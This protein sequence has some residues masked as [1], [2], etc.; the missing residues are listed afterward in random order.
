MDL[1]YAAADFALCRAGAMTCAELTAV[2]L[3]GAYVPLPHG[4]GEQRLNAEPIVAG[5]GGLMVDDAD[6]TP[7]WIRTVLL[8][9]LLDI[10]RVANMSEAA[11]ALGRKDADR[12]LAAAVINVVRAAHEAAAAPGATARAARPGS[13]SPPP[14]SPPRGFA[15]RPARRAPRALSPRRKGSPCLAARAR[16]ASPLRTASPPG[17]PA[18]GRAA[19]P[20]GRH[21]AG[22]RAVS[23]IRVA[24]AGPGRSAPGRGR[25][26]ARHGRSAAAGRGQRGA[27]VRAPLATPGGSLRQHRP[28]RTPASGPA[29]HR[30]PGAAPGPGGLRGA[31]ECRAT[32]A[33]GRAAAAVRAPPG[34]APPGSAPARPAPLTCTYIRPVRRAG[35]AR[36]DPGCLGVAA[37]LFRVTR[38]NEAQEDVPWPW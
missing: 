8:P 31:P 6:L 22:L 21:P 23:R 1:A 5:G 35:A 36:L 27:L 4:N 3:P 13:S 37:G 18:S 16:T 24:A 33:R 30:R 15:S 28:G 10:D 34:W 14:S 7:D 17:P 32:L 11:A 20:A 2:G 29:A 12:A 25:A 26:A 9:V 38:H 19:N